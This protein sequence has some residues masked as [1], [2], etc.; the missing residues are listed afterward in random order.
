MNQS[1][2][3]L[4]GN[5][6]EP[7]ATHWWDLGLLVIISIPFIFW[8]IGSVSFLDP[9]EGLYGS[10]AR[11]MAEGGGWVT[12]HFNGV[13]YLEKPPL[14]FWLSAL[15]ISLLGPSEWGV[16]LWSALPAFGTALLVWRMG[17]W[18]Y[19]R[20]SGI[21]AAIVFISSAGIFR[22]VRV[23][24]TDF[25]LVFSITLAIFGFLK[26]FLS[27]ASGTW[28]GANGQPWSM[29]NR[30]S[31]TVDQAPVVRTGLLLFYLGMAFGVLSKG[32]IGVVFPLLI[33]G[34]FLLVT[35]FKGQIVNGQQSMVNGQWGWR[36]TID[37]L[38]LTIY[39]PAGLILFLVL[40]LP[41]HL[42]AAF[43]NSGFFEFYIIDNQIL[44]FLNTRAFLEDD[45]PIRT[46]SFL[47]VTLIW[48][49]PWSL[50]LPAALR[51]GFPRFHRKMDLNQAARLLVGIW[52]L[53]ILAFF[54]F[55]FFEA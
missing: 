41:W 49:F 53:G 52:G 51:Q 21:L 15:T 9:D 24:A 48:F 36:R 31:S 37:Y 44:R 28:R 16:R 43:M 11:E 32:F 26:A 25:L 45:I 8:G 35:S 18:L 55:S 47:V 30:Q 5:T 2:Q 6:L 4:Q 54:C 13:R 20:N 50:T 27:L 1:N 40:V 22:Y 23:A 7:N 3:S 12:P 19:G 29:V 14:Q 17:T 34:S 42:L 33:V 38:R 39:S 46:L 10:I